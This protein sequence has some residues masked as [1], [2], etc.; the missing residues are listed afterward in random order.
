MQPFVSVAAALL[1][2]VVG[3]A[4]AWLAGRRQHRLETAF[5]MHREFHTPEMTRSRN[6]AGEDGDRASFG[7]LRG[8]EKGAAPRRNA[9]C[10]ERLVLLPASLAG[11]QIQEYP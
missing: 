8:N 7:Q 5:A 6:L 9:A 1:G 10:L 2:T 11:D 3:A 4:I